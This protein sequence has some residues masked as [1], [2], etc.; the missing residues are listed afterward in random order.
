MGL[1]ENFRQAFQEL[2]GGSPPKDNA[3]KYDAENIRKVLDDEYDEDTDNIASA[4]EP[5]PND[6]IEIDSPVPVAKPVTGN[7]VSRLPI[8]APQIEGSIATEKPRQPD[9]PPSNARNNANI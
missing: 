2:T 9:M 6:L 4:P 1:R 3:P 5:T 8:A 7:V